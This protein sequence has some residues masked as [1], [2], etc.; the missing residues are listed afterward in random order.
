MIERGEQ[1][2]LG[3]QPGEL[4][5]LVAGR[6]AGKLGERTGL[7]RGAQRQPVDARDIAQR[8]DDPAILGDPA[9]PAVAR[10]RNELD[11]T[12]PLPS[13]RSPSIPT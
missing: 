5:P 11:Q 9:D 10:G 1:A 7:L 2:I 8:L 12:Q 3:E 13:S 4:D 6:P